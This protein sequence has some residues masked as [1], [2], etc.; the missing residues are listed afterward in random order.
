MIR[1]IYPLFM[2]FVIGQ[3]LI[4]TYSLPK[5]KGGEIYQ[6]HTLTVL[7]LLHLA[8]MIGSIVEFYG[9][10]RHRGIVLSVSALGFVLYMGALLLRNWAKYTLGQFWSLQVEILPGHRII[11]E[12]PYQFVRHPAYTA[13][14]MEI[15][16]IPL[17][18][19]AYWTFIFFSIPYLFVLIWRV[20]V[21]E[22]AL[23]RV[24]GSSYVRF[25]QEVPQFLP[26]FPLR[27][28]R[29]VRSSSEP[30]QSENIDSAENKKS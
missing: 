22:R 17:V 9:L 21:E 10:A 7:T 3:R 11:R 26:F 24:A 5:R 6:P 27:Q 19:N 18:A 14:M 13:I 25:Q 15:I 8:C 20:R 28:F 12:G 2:T 30:V 1:F 23:A 29:D 4:E 16:G